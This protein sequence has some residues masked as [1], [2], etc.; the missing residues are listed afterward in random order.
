[1]LS[2]LGGCA[3]ARGAPSPGRGAFLLLGP[4]PRGKETRGGGGRS[5]SPR[6]PR[7]RF[8]FAS[9]LS[10]SSPETKP[11]P[12]K[13]FALR[14]VC[15]CVFW[16]LVAGGVLNPGGPALGVFAS[17]G[18]FH[19]EIVGESSLS[20]LP[21]S[22]HLAASRFCSDGLRTDRRGQGKGPCGAGRRGEERR[23]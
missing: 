6:P 18:C 5:G 1:M 12:T 3:R 19:R 14:G 11:E 15:V 23:F 10:A 8:P 17:G 2:G 4:S 20:V 7:L 13:F 16:V 21:A 9:V 22:V